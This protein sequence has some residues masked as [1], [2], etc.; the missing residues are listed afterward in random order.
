MSSHNHPAGN[1][2]VISKEQYER[3]NYNCRVVKGQLKFDTEHQFRVQLKKSDTGVPVVR[4]HANLVADD[5]Y[6]EIEYY[7]RIS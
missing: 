1:Y 4:G 2:I 6:P 5:E 7:D 3:P